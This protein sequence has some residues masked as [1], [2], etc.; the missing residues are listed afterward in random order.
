[1]LFGDI[2]P[3]KRGGE[4]SL[5]HLD[6]CYARLRNLSTATVL[7]SLT[8]IRLH[9]AT[10]SVNKKSLATRLLFFGVV[11]VR[12]Q[13]FTM[14]KPIQSHLKYVSVTT[15]ASSDTSN[16]LNFGTAFRYIFAATALSD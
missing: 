11:S 16:V 13:K 5:Q 14:S 8:N 12:I 6:E 7:P 10:D 3:T 1:M 15:A 9:F 2:S 4:F